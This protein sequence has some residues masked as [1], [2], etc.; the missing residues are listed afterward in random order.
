ME[1]ITISKT[2]LNNLLENIIEK[3]F[4]NL[5]GFEEEIIEIDKN[6]KF[7]SYNNFEEFK[8]KIENV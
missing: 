1:T 6:G 8:N 7:N 4:N 2:E 3:K 5:M